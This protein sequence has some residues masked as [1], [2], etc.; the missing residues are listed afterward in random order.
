MCPED[1]YK[2]L[3]TLDFGRFRRN[4]DQLIARL[5]PTGVSFDPQIDQWGAGHENLASRA[6]R[7]SRRRRH[8]GDDAGGQRTASQRGGVHV[9]SC[10]ASPSISPSA[11]T[12]DTT[13]G[14]HN[15]YDIGST[16]NTYTVNFLEQIMGFSLAGSPITPM[17][18]NGT[19]G[20]AGSYG[21]YLT[22]QNLTQ[23]IGPPNTY[24]Y[25]SGSVV[26]MLDPANNNGLA[27]ST[28]TGLTFANTGP[29]GAADDITLATGTLVSGQYS[30]NP[31]SLIRS[32]GDFVQTFQPAAGEGGFFVSPV[33]PHDMIQLVDTT[34]PNDIK[35]T[36]EPS[37]SDPTRSM[38][39][40]NGEPGSAVINLLVPEPAPFL[41]LGSGLIGLAALRRRTRN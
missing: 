4:S 35:I 31:T 23:F 29:T 39:V 34:F 9:G 24:Q 11:F 28:L 2:I 14:T 22:M 19:P 26:L 13:F 5:P 3:A 30:L 37:A 27:S 17:G 38:S 6:K 1:D 33:S 8:A 41:L 10:G 21:L 32:I 15:L 36:P 40:L 20:A 12:A 16:M 18:F 7:A 25:L